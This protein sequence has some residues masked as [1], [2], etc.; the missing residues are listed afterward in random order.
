MAPADVSRAVP[1]LPPDGD[2]LGDVG[3]GVKALPDINSCEKPAPF[4]A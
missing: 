1:R 2:R 3:L 4:I